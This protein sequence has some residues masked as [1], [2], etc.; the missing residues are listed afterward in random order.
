[1]NSVEGAVLKGYDLQKNEGLERILK[2]TSATG[3][4]RSKKE[5][6]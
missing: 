2:I 1:M 3:K 4:D 6:N 5:K